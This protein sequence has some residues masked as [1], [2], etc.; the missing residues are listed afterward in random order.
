[1]KYYNTRNK[2]VMEIL[3]QDE[4]KGTMLIKFE[5]GTSTS[6]TTGTFKRWYRQVEDNVATE[7]ETPVN[8][9]VRAVV[10]GDTDEEYIQEVMQQKKDLGIECPPIKEVEVVETN[11]VPMPGI[12]K[13]ADLKKEYSK[14]KKEKKSKKSTQDI[15]SVAAKLIKVV[16]KQGFTTHRV[17]NAPRNM[18]IGFNGKNSYGIYIG[19]TKFVLG[20]AGTK[21]PDGYTA[22][23]VRNCPQSHTFDMDYDNLDKLVTM[24]QAIKAK[25][26]K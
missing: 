10:D 20:M 3:K 26:E 14:P 6:I 16:E 25:E 12:E 15:E 24:L 4:K 19:G 17:P 9:P 23:R 8:E 18:T 21:V 1:M 22:D 7:I 5:D 11:L 2:K 13:L